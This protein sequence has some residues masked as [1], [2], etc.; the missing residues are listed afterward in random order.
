MSAFICQ[1]KTLQ[2]IV[3]YFDLDTRFV[4]SSICHG[5]IGR[6][7]QEIGFNLEYKEHKD[8]LIK[9]MVFLNRQAV[10]DRY[11]EYETEQNI[12]YRDEFPATPIQVYKSL[13]CFLYQCAEGDIP[14]KNELYKTLEEIK[15]Y[16]AECIVGRLPEFDKAEWD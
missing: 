11:S 16:M 10:N 4:N 6:K 1:D 15:S 8:R 5:Q 2:R 13:C 7:L 14:E 9:E 12:I 3:C